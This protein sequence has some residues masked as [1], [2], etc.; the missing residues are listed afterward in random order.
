MKTRD[1]Q[2][3]LKPNQLVL[4]CFAERDQD[5]SWFTMCL[6]LNLYARGDSYEHARK[7]L[8]SVIVAY[9][10]DALAGPE[11]DYISDL[12]PRPA[13]LYFWLRY[14]FIWCC[15]KLRNVTNKRK[16]REFLPLVPAA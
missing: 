5:G 15:V 2:V 14:A 7:K 1:P 6:D 3:N 13:P 9:L 11:K 4:R 8:H 16:F 10:K 12:I